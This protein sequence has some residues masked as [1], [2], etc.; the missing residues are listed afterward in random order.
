MACA[1]TRAR[2]SARVSHT[3]CRPR[4][5][6]SAWKWRATGLHAGTHAG[7]ATLQHCRGRQRADPTRFSRGTQRRWKPCQR[8]IRRPLSL[9]YSPAAVAPR[10]PFRPLRGSLPGSARGV[11]AGGP[12]C[13]ACAAQGRARALTGEGARTGPG[14]STSTHRRRS[15]NRP[16]G[17]HEPL[18]HRE[19]IGNRGVH[20]KAVMVL[21]RPPTNLSYACQKST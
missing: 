5:Y 3:V 17:E 12:R 15:A 6:G 20:Q 21:A 9:P 8:H 13:P 2:A 16:R 11:R 7:E 1:D 14:A 18:R 4:S 10:P 19:R